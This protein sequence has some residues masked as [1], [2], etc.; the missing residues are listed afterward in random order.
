MKH[1]AIIT[2]ITSR[3]KKLYLMAI[4]CNLFRIVIFEMEKDF[5]F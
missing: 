1:N 3:F 5:V 4:K 2:Y